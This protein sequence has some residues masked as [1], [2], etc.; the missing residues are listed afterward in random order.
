VHVV[1]AAFVVVILG[2]SASADID[3][4]E[5]DRLF[6]EAIKLR[7]VNIT[8]ACDK[9]AQALRFNPQAIGTRLN[10][11]LCDERLGKIASAVEKF[12]EVADRAREQN[13]D[14][15]R[16]VAEEHLAVLKPNVPHITIKLE[17][18]IGPD[19]KIVVDDRVVTK[20]Q[21]VRLPIDPGE[22]TI[23]VSAPGRVSH[24]AKL[25]F[26]KGEHKALTIPILGRR[27][28]SR[29]TLAKVSVIGGGVL[30]ATGIGI[31]LV[32]RSRYNTAIANCPL[33]PDTDTFVC[34]EP[35][36]VSAI[37]RAKT[38]GT[39]GSVVGVVGIVAGVA[40]GV[41]WWRSAR[42]ERS[43]VAFVGPMVD[44]TSIGLAAAGRF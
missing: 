18:T 10:V 28:N 22:R 35:G 4:K 7:D 30:L 33:D 20:D 40:G 5:A 39:V 43:G 41:L 19:F 14:E 44:Q 31:G 16:K 34:N 15:Y 8:Q 26:G 29:V 3:N 37:D 1:R 42:A 6:Q 17:D 21:L 32:A 25:M 27:S 11:A 23:V 36:E 12:S 9:F 13:L 38:L 24:V 2:R